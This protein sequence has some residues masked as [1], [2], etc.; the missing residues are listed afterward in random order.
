MGRLP[1]EQFIYFG[2]REPFGGITL[3]G[4]GAVVLLPSGDE[5]TADAVFSQRQY[6]RKSGRD[7]VLSRV[8]NQ[9]VVDEAV[10]LTD[11]DVVFAIDTNTKN[12]ESEAVS[13]SC[14]LECYA[15]Q[16]TP[17]QVEVSYSEHMLV[18]K[19]CEDEPAERFG[20]YRLTR[21]VDGSPIFQG[22]ARIGVVTDHDLTRHGRYQAGEVPIYGAHYL[23]NRFTL[24]YATSDA[25]K[26][27]V[28][29]RLIAEC[30][31][32]AGE[33]LRQLEDLGAATLAGRTIT[34][35]TIADARLAE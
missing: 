24:I 25:G 14:F 11:F 5:V 35:E 15:R 21:I 18:F 19:N 1:R 16:V 4:N 7:K 3:K 34:V 9:A 28:L 17:S 23:P 12:I 10:L 2:H 29:N 27:G 32:Q 20:W 30:D 33:V 13:V 26:G 22:K 6:T 31:K 8:P